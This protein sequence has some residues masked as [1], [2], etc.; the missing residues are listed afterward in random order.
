MD[1]FLNIDG[2]RRLETYFEEL[3]VLLGDVRRKASFAMY[4]MGLILDGDRKSM[5]PI[6]ARLAGNPEDTERAHDHLQHLLTDGKWKDRDVRRHAAYTG[7]AA[8][9]EHDQVRSWILDDTGFLKQGIHSVGVQRQYTG[10]AGKTANCQVAVSLTIASATDHVPID[11]ELYLPECWANDPK[12]R[13]E[14][15]IPDDIGFRTKPEL[16]LVVIDRAL[17]DGIPE[18]VVLADSA[19]GDSSSF[20]YELRLRELDYAVGVNPLTKVWRCDSRGR[21]RGEPISIQK[22][23][24]QLPRNAIAGVRGK[25]EPTTPCTRASP[26]CAWCRSTTTE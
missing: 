14:A 15:K 2:Q 7:V 16:A 5:E 9:M 10:S 18:G 26:G 3:G 11:F 13:L 17:E 6:A 19:Y 20:R 21:R 12:R 25:K 24:Q 8:L 1:N 22:L 4:C 23:A